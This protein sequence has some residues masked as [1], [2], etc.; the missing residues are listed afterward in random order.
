MILRTRTLFRFALAGVVVAT[1]LCVILVA[2]AARQVRVQDAVYVGG[3]IPWPGQYLMV[4]FDRSYLRS[5]NSLTPLLVLCV[6][7]NAPVYALFGLLYL[8]FF[9]T[10]KE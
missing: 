1:L 9:P 7:T 5:L 6:L 10:T 3:L 4:F 2:A 8:R